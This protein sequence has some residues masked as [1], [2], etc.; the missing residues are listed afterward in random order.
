MLRSFIIIEHITHILI[1]LVVIHKLK[2]FLLSDDGLLLLLG[3][4]LSRIKKIVFL[5]GLLLGKEANGGKLFQKPLIRSL[6]IKFLILFI[7][8]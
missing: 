6:Q 4:H 7:I 2:P 3:S 8:S 5:R 1:V